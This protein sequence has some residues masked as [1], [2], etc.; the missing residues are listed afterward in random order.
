[1]KTM[2]DG[3][4]IKLPNAPYEHADG[5]TSDIVRE[6][7]LNWAIHVQHARSKGW[8][9]YY[10]PKYRLAMILPTRNSQKKPY[11]ISHPKEDY[12]GRIEKATTRRSNG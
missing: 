3:D 6:D 1:M 4:G 12:D 11:S 5:L 9:L 2:K 10:Y 7:W 8:K